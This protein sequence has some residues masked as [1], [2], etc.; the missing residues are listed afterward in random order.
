MKVEKITVI[1]SLPY[2][3][4]TFRSIFEKYERVVREVKENQGLQGKCRVIKAT[5]RLKV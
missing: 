4:T 2:I 1:D 3:G 5:E